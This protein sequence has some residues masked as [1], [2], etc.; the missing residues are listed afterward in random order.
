M[1]LQDRQGIAIKISNLSKVYKV[2]EKHKLGSEIE[3][4]IKK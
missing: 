2:Y 3:R 1:N 4:F